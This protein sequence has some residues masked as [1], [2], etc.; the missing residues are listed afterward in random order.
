MQNQFQVV[1][2]Q[3]NS[4][5]SQ[6][7]TKN[8]LYVSDLPQHTTESDL[9]TFF[10]EFK[11]N[12]A[13]IN[14]N[15]ASR[16]QDIYSPKSMSAT[17]VFRDYKMADAARKQLNMR[18]IKGKTIRVVWHER[19]NTTRYN[20]QTNV[21]I[22]NIRFDVKPREFY[23]FF[24]KFGDILSAKLPED[25]EGNHLGYGYINYTDPESAARAIK[26]A[27]GQQ[28]LGSSL[29]VKLFQKKN[30]RLS[31]LSIKNTNIYLKNF[32]LNFKEEDLKNLCNQFGDILLSKIVVDNQNRPFAIV[33]YTTEESAVSAK[34][35]LNQKEING[36]ELFVD[37]LMS[38]QERKKVLS[39]KILDSNY[40]F[41][42][43]YKLCNLHVRNLP[44]HAKDEDLVEAFKDFGK[45][46]SVKIEK[47]ILV[48][49]ENNEFVQIPT[50]KGFGYVCFED[51]E[52][53]KA[54]LEQMNGKFLAKFE[55]W[56]RPLLLDYF[57]PKFERN[58]VYSKINNPMNK[59]LGMN[60]PNLGMNPMMPSMNPMMQQGYG[61]PYAMPGNQMFMNPGFQQFPP[62]YPPQKRNYQQRKNNFQHKP[63]PQQQPI[64]QPTK[65][66]D[67]I[68]FAYLQNLEDEYA[69][70]DYL[71]EFIFKKIENHKLSQQENFTIDTI[72]KITGMIL[73]I[74]DINEI[75]DISRNS[76]NLTARITEAL[77]LLNSQM[78]A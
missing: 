13:V 47:Y 22:K 7:P 63:T 74:E 75:V 55:S 20:S 76:D 62:N 18:K 39:N 64:A 2:P 15:P 16:H 3:I 5:T 14:I 57:M 28:G 61:N 36:Q 29:E 6:E 70:R 37:N 35:A 53:A 68:D 11:D 54:A 9:W 66:A 49:K 72:G 12:I 60:N 51:P 24:I 10:E 34:N 77:E 40:K 43:Q 56:K 25:E 71:G 58:N 23:E 17:V 33:S 21:F 65:S 41:S 73:G 27:D 59:G 8:L 32:P 42:E 69:K 50:S 67:D 48:T 30:E 44:Y 4:G 52:A 38:K 46:K 26:A 31:A 19:D 45:I 78:N 1:V